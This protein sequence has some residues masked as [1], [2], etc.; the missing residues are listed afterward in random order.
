MKQCLTSLVG[1]VPPDRSRDRTAFDTS[2]KFASRSGTI[3][4][5]H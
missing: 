4:C 5:A 1:A 3:P 2:Y